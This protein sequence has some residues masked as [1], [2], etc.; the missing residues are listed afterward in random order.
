MNAPNK[1]IWFLDVQLAQEDVAD[2]RT[3]T[4]DMQHW[5]ESTIIALARRSATAGLTS[6]KILFSEQLSGGDARAAGRPE[7]YQIGAQPVSFP[8]PGRRREPGGHGWL[9][10]R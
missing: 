2:G 4:D 6:I 8:G 7:F 1:R 9:L 5:A 10:Q 3:L